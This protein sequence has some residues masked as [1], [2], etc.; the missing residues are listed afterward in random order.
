MAF[1][2]QCGTQTIP[3]ANFCENCGAPTGRSESYP[4]VGT[5]AYVEP[6]N[7]RRKRTVML[8]AI[9]G[10]LLL[11]GVVAVVGITQS[12]TSDTINSAETADGNVQ[13]DS[14]DGQ[15]C[16]RYAHQPTPQERQAVGVLS[17]ADYGQG[18]RL[19]FEAVGFR[20]GCPVKSEDYSFHSYYSAVDLIMLATIA[21]KMPGISPTKVA[22]IN[23]RVDTL[24]K[25]VM[26][27]PEIS[28]KMKDSLVTGQR[29]MMQMQRGQAPLSTR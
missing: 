22:Q 15:T 12:R 26:S 18:G 6:P 23:A 25:L 16:H 9:F 27:D 2:R 14:S 21:P 10:V 24:V 3:G 28:A 20:L 7:T 11:V 8:F 5:E 29:S 4:V 13:N 19:L 1:C 17:K